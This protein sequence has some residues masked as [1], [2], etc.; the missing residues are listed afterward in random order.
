MTDYSKTIIYKIVCKD[1]TIT[2]FYIGSTINFTKRKHCH[3]NKCNNEKDKNYNLKVYQTIRNNGGFE[4]WSMILVENYPCKNK[5]EAE[6]REQYWKDELKPDLNIMNCFIYEFTKKENPEEFNKE[7]YQKILLKNPNYIK[8]RYEKNLLKNPDFYKEKYQ[9][10]KE[11]KLQKITCDCGSITC[12]D[13]LSNHK[14]TLKHKSYELS[15][16]NN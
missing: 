14:K 4:N 2:S 9:K 3:K 15:L 6:K 16:I 11:K 13:N 8:E 7:Y 12:Y 5:R 1:P 10:N